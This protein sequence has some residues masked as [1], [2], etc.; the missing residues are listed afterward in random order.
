RLQFTLHAHRILPVESALE[1]AFLHVRRWIGD[2]HRRAERWIAGGTKL[3]QL[4]DPIAI[5]IGPGPRVGTGA[6]EYGA[7][8]RAAK[9]VELIRETDRLA[10][11]IATDARLYSGLTVPAEV[12]REAEARIDVFPRRQIGELAQCAHRDE[13]SRREVLRFEFG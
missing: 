13:G 1:P 7:R 5:G 4:H 2:Q 3:R 6:G 12:V 8:Y 10:R 9:R 11:D